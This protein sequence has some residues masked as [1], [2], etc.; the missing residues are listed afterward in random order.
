MSHPS[1]SIAAGFVP[2]SGSA[3]HGRPSPLVA[4]PSQARDLVRR[5]SGA[6]IAIVKFRRLCGRLGTLPTGIGSALSCALAG[7]F[8]GGEQVSLLALHDPEIGMESL[9]DVPEALGE[10]PIV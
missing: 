5:T 4:H 1:S 7:G 10:I 9:G 6:E 2:A 3:R 8:A